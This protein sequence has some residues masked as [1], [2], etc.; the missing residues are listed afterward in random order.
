M[1]ESKR[2]FIDT[3]ILIYLT[4][5]DFENKKHINV[6][7]KIEEFI[8]DDYELYIS[9]QILREF[10]AISTNNKLF[11]TPLSIEDSIMKVKEYLKFFNIIYELDS[12]IH[13]VLKLCK[14][15]KIKKQNIHDVNIVATMLDN[16]IRYIFTYNKKDFT[17]INEIKTI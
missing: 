9:P 8:Q 15:Y 1:I 14:K 12:T 11:K 2:I 4:F 6:R 7:N 3:N 10:Y 13:R 17:N 5:S 16:D